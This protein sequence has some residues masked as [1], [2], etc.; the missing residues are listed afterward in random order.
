MHA[1][2]VRGTGHDYSPWVNN[3]RPVPPGAR[4][5]LNVQC[6]PKEVDDIVRDEVDIHLNPVTPPREYPVMLGV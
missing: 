2:R 4:F 1:I 6:T 5:T 3:F